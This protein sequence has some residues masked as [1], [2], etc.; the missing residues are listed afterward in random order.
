MKHCNKS[1]ASIRKCIT[2]VEFIQ[3]LDCAASAWIKNS[4]DLVKILVA[5]VCCIA[6]SSEILMQGIKMC[7]IVAIVFV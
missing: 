4:N 6:V 3:N 5:I 2:I 1:K 7:K